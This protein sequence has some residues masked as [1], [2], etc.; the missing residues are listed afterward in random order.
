[1]F[2][3]LYVHLYCNNNPQPSTTPPAGTPCAEHSSPP[4]AHYFGSLD[5][6][7]GLFC[8]GLKLP[9][10]AFQENTAPVPGRNHL[11][12][13]VVTITDGDTQHHSLFVM[14]RRYEDYGGLPPVCACDLVNAQ[15]F[16]QRLRRMYR[17]Q[18][19]TGIV[20]LIERFVQHERDR[21]FYVEFYPF[22][23]GHGGD[24]YIKSLMGRTGSTAALDHIVELM[25]RQTGRMFATMEPHS[26]CRPANFLIVDYKQVFAIDCRGPLIALDR[27]KAT[28]PAFLFL[29]MLAAIIKQ[30]LS[31]NITDSTD[32]KQLS[33]IYQTTF[34]TCRE[35]FIRG[36][37]R[38][39][40]GNSL[41][42]DDEDEGEKIIL[43]PEETI[44]RTNR[45]ETAVFP[46]APDSDDDN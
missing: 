7:V 3:I 32:L 10:A 30:K 31:E 40:Q 38:E 13:G 5:D 22:V 46:Y 2:V 6:V 20:P 4:V 9:C 43:S 41:L 28:S 11:K 39:F 18:Q 42:D 23:P 27:K 36:M 15:V 14:Q 37:E 24:V 35:G 26:D 34:A 44:R 45:F 33:A 16:E 17:I 8:N 21:Q 1:L 12:T 19:E 25:G 29:K